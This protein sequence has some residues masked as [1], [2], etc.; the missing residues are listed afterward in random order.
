MKDKIKVWLFDI[1]MAID[2]IES[3]FEPGNKIFDK[4]KK[5]VKNQ[6][7]GGAQFGNYRRSSKTNFGSGQTNKFIQCAKDRGHAKQN[8]PRL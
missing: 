4:Y 8:Y 1:L 7:G 3:F 5:D 6:T 2:E